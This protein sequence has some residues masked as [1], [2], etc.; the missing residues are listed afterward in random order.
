MA[1]ILQS[2]L[3]VELVLPFVLVFAVVFA[4]LQKTEIL[5]KGKKQVDSIVA[6]V[7]ALIFVSFARAIEIVTGLIPF[8]VVALVII[9]VFM[10]LIGMLFKQGEF[11]LDKMHKGW[12][13][14]IAGIVAVAVVIAVL[15]ITDAWDYLA[16]LFSGDSGGGI[17]TNVIF[18]VI[19]IVAVAVVVMG[20]G[21]SG[22]NG[23][24]E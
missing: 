14:A 22:G 23:K 21:K 15:V 19:V 16:F 7:V 10:I 11:G 13:L 20:G 18:V 9:L 12:R 1:T 24:D 17:L 2:P 4:V 3:F 6:L 8:L 5:G